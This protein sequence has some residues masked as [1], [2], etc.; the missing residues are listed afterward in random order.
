LTEPKNMTLLELT[1]TRADLGAA[2]ND[3]IVAE[4]K[5]SSLVAQLDLAIL[6]HPENPIHRREGTK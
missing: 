1:E 6:R 4:A 2:L 5:V 3:L